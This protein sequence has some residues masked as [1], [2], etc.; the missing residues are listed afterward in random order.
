MA[1]GIAPGRSPRGDPRM[2]CD[3]RARWAAGSPPARKNAGLAGDRAGRHPR[4]GYGKTATAR[5]LGAGPSTSVSRQPAGAGIQRI[6]T[7][8]TTGRCRLAAKLCCAGTRKTVNH[9]R[10]F[11]R[12]YLATAGIK[13][14]CT[15][16]A[17]P[18][19]W[20]PVRISLVR[21][22]FPLLVVTSAI[23]K[24]AISVDIAASA[25]YPSESRG[26]DI[27]GSGPRGR[28]G[29]RPRCDLFGGGRAPDAKLTQ[30]YESASP[31]V[32]ARAN[33]PSRGHSPNTG[34]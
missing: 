13:T 6:R 1:T 18:S 23:G 3:A 17:E 21:I 31:E 7:R 4:D 5:H 10:R 19:R 24:R 28:V 27:S 9:E 15:R 22:L 16:P 26:P 8:G 32:W 30:C 11:S 34:R 14:Q 29:Q 2:R 25:D 33:R 20:R 12:R